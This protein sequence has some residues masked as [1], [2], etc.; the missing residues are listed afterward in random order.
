MSGPYKITLIQFKVMRL[1]HR[2]A[3]HALTVLSM[4]AG[5]LVRYLT[6]F[7]LHDTL[8]YSALTISQ[9]FG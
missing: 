9:S 1:S 7:L 3:V 6:L 5:K 2:W 8:S 4:A